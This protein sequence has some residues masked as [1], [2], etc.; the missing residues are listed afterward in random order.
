MRTAKAFQ[1][2]QGFVRDWAGGAEGAVGGPTYSYQPS[3]VQ[4]R[5]G[6]RTHESELLLATQESC[7]VLVTQPQARMAG[8]SQRLSHP[9]WGTAKPHVLDT[10]RLSS[11]PIWGRVGSS[12]PKTL[13]V[14]VPGTHG[15]SLP[16]PVSRN[17]EHLLPP[18]GL[19]M[20]QVGT[21][22]RLMGLSVIRADATV[23]PGHQAEDRGQG[24]SRMTKP[25]P[26]GTPCGRNP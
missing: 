19:H 4:R 6:P 25:A 22:I 8:A 20:W 12:R 26:V 11:D 18:M 1:G 14:S 13:S 24:G 10:E 17:S 15:P 5:K 16:F 2:V 23:S 21:S 3:R 9:E 7:A